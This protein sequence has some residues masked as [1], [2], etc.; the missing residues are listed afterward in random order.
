MFPLPSPSHRGSERNRRSTYRDLGGVEELEAE[1]VCLHEVQVVHDLIEQVLAF[2]VFLEGKW[3][4][5]DLGHVSQGTNKKI[6]NKNTF[7]CI[8]HICI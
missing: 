2:G 1:V 4:D 3:G 5:G 8:L 7:L 6:K